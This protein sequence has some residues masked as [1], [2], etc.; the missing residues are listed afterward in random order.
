MLLRLFVV[1]GKEVGRIHFEGTSETDNVIQADVLFSPFHLYDEVAG[2][3]GF[4]GHADFGSVIPLTSKRKV[5]GS[6]FA[7]A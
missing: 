7:S 6:L 5:Y 3:V 4:A 2:N 1:K